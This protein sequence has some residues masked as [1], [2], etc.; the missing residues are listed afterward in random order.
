MWIKFFTSELWYSPLCGRMSTKNQLSLIEQSVFT[1]A[2]RKWAFKMYETK[3]LLQVLSEFSLDYFTSWNVL[4]SLFLFISTVN[5]I[6]RK[7]HHWFT[8]IFFLG[9]V[10]K[11]A[12]KLLSFVCLQSFIVLWLPATRKFT[13]VSSGACWQWRPLCTECKCCSAGRTTGTPQNKLTMPRLL[14][15]LYFYMIL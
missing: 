7:Q 4:F 2:Q 15:E 9:L 10:I 11:R 1:A 8:V 14:A 13:E 12:V 5:I 3:T 6:E